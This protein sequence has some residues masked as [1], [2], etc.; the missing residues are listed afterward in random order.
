M[1]GQIGIIFGQKHRSRKEMDHFRMVFT[2]LLLLSEKR[3]PHA[4]GVAWLKQNGEHNISKRPGRAIDL[5]RDSTF[6]RFIA[7]VDSDVT[8]LAGHTRWQTR[9]DAS[10]NRNNHPIRAGEVIGTHNGTITN[11]DSLFTHFRLPRSAEVDSELLFRLAEAV[12]TEGCIDV[13]AFKARLALCKGQVSAVMASLLNPQKVV[14]IKGNKPLYIRYNRSYHVVIYSSDA[15]YLDIAL[16][17]D[18]G[19]KPVGL[20][21]MTIATFSCDDLKAMKFEP[22]EMAN[23]ARADCCQKIVEETI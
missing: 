3:G 11:A 17:D 19:W 16:T 12:L 18:R 4:T 1:C 10:N 21:P 6:Y 14:L 22:F 20:K 15:S 7:A 23:S 2:H 5:V 13:T 9:G 8:W